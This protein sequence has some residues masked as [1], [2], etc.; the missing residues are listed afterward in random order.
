MKRRGF[1]ILVL[2]YY[3]NF[4]LCD[5]DEEYA[6]TAPPITP[7]NFV[8]WPNGSVPFFINS[9]H[10]D[11]EQTL[12]IMTSLSLIAFKTCLKFAPV[13]VPPANHEH[14]LTFE[15]PRGTRKCEIHLHG[16]S[17]DE[18]HIVT[19]GYDCL[20]AP[21]MD[22][23][24]L[25]ALG[26][27]F[28]HNR[29]SRDSFIDVQFENIEQH[30]IPLFTKDIALP[31]ALRALPYDVNSVMHFGDRDFSKN[32]HRTII[33]KDRDTKQKWDGPS[34]LDLRKIEIIYGA[35]CRER[36]RQE[37]IELCHMYPGVPLV[38]RKRSVD[39]ETTRSLR[40]NPDIT[41]PPELNIPKQTQ[42]IL[43]N[44]DIEDDVQKIIEEV[45]KLSNK[46]L[47]NTRGKYC[48]VS[49][50]VLRSTGEP[51]DIHG[52]IQIVADYAQNMVD[53]AVSNLTSFCAESESIEKYQRQACGGYCPKN[54]YSTK[55]FKPYPST[56]NRPYIPQST[57]HV[58]GF[59]KRPYDPQYHLRAQ[60]DVR[61]QSQND[62]KVE[63]HDRKKRQAL[64]TAL[65]R[66][67]RLADTK[68]DSTSLKD[69]EVMKRSKREVTEL[70]REGR[71]AR[72]QKSKSNANPRRYSEEIEEDETQS[73]EEW[74]ER[75]KKRPVVDASE[76]NQYEGKKPRKPKDNER[77]RTK[78]QKPPVKRDSEEI[79]EV[80]SDDDDETEEK[81]DERNDKRYKKPLNEEARESTEEHDVIKPKPVKS[82]MKTVM[83]SKEN[84]EFYNQRKWPDG[85]VRYLI[86][87]TSTKFDLKD[88]RR[89]L[90]IVNALLSLE[91]C[92]QIEEIREGDTS[93][94]ED[95]LVLDNSPD[96]VTGRVGGR[97]IFG[98]P[99][100]LAGGQHRQHTAMMVMAMLGFYFEL[101]R[102]DRDEYVKIHQRHIR[103]DK[104]HHF[105]KISADAT[106][107]LPYDYESATHPPWMYWR[108]LGKK[109]ISTVATYKDKDPDGSIMRRLGQNKKLLSETDII[110]INSVYG[111]K[112]KVVDPKVN[113]PKSDWDQ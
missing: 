88:L 79:F 32:G 42:D 109:G 91:T 85:V 106:L 61:E 16:H 50:D 78:H 2:Y 67:E 24:V 10:F 52:I 87:R 56:K 19:L 71:R 26:L 37:K 33:F 103:A 62:T 46:A 1:K 113:Q 48:N 12:I 96:F 101:A 49:K 45:F 74:N 14:V 35:E 54:Y 102:H 66:Q 93:K 76:E 55:V 105:E 5:I 57:K 25:G 47:I 28:E 59:K 77:E 112:C 99:E 90:G 17:S 8:A 13:M 53:H 4:V 21:W 41:P 65:R 9:E 68:N 43:T 29:Q 70:N 39:L 69:G 38:R 75:K 6:R 72:R 63:P 60:E 98:T 11:N 108:K 107:P 30:A 40:V 15:N 94:H 44:L 23:I 80:Y 73:S 89:R 100:L 95:Y 111:A 3:I 110:K 31:A 34:E 82:P 22:R 27:P 51:V 92:V 81:S 18:P 86:N 64:D 7:P 58:G 104:L 83:L 97:Q 20:E 84:E 36:D